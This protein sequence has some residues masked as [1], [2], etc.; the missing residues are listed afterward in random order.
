[1]TTSIAEGGGSVPFTPSSE[2]P[3][4]GNTTPSNL[5][6]TGWSYDNPF[7]FG[8]SFGVSPS[9]AAPVMS[10]PWSGSV[11][12]MD[13][14]LLL[15]QMTSVPISSAFGRNTVTKDMRTNYTIPYA[16]AQNT[17]QAGMDFWKGYYEGLPMFLFTG[18]PFATPYGVFDPEANFYLT[19][20]RYGGFNLGDEYESYF[21]EKPYAGFSSNYTLAQTNFLLNMELS[22]TVYGGEMGEGCYKREDVAEMF[23]FDGIVYNQEGGENPATGDEFDPGKGIIYNIVREGA[24]RNT[25]NCWSNDIGVQ[26]N[27]WFICKRADPPPGGYRI[28]PNDSKKILPHVPEKLLDALPKEKRELYESRMNTRPWQFIPWSSRSKY[29][30]TEEDLT[31]EDEFGIERRGFAVYVGLNRYEPP[32]INKEVIK[33]S[34]YDSHAAVQ[35]EALEI[36]LD[37]GKMILF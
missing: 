23:V 25:R 31:S 5:G 15:E 10:V 19:D 35:G 7:D 8:T 28:T 9:P 18:R 29:G 1:M 26:D 6:T 21:R 30:P 32:I 3:F 37:Q 17:E 4:I 16:R 11:S 14:N 2:I 22:R 24:H 27:L 34:R 13:S 36:Y 33:M 12:S 20:G